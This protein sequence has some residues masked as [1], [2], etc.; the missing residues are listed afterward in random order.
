MQGKL[1]KT[2]HF[3]KTQFS[4]PISGNLKIKC[5]QVFPLSIDCEQISCIKDNLI[6]CLNQ[7]PDADIAELKYEIP[8]KIS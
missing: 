7:I 1:H 3:P 5:I 4:I 8:K 6:T 2:A